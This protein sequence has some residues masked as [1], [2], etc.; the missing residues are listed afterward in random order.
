MKKILISFII[1]VLTICMCNFSYAE[2][3]PNI[4]LNLTEERTITREDETVTLILSFGKFTEIEE[5]ALLG[6]EAILEYDENIF[7]KVTVKGLNG[8][9]V[10]YSDTTKRIV[11]DP[12][13]GQEQTNIAEI[14]FTVKEGAE[15]GT[16]TIK[17]KDILLSDDIN[18][19][20]YNKESRITIKEVEK[21]EG[22][23]TPI[24]P[25]NTTE[26][27]SEDKTVTITPTT[28]TEQTKASTE[29]PYAGVKSIIAIIV[30]IIIIAIISIVRY[31]S[32]EIK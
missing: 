5:N 15:L 18:D 29:I 27:P 11:S 22:K 24:Q 14:I 31:K 32:I 1:T 16:T 25:D 28:K 30:T 2:T 8:W 4:E 20:E 23:T 7:E 13:V 6:Y 3:E 19:F 21:E 26:Q 12:K 9:I 10:S 17:L